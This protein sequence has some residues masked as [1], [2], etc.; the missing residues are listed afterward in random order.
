MR[1]MKAGEA[2]DPNHTF[3]DPGFGLLKSSSVRWGRRR[4]ATP[5]ARAASGTPAPPRAGAATS[6]GDVNA[7]RH[8]GKCHRRRLR[9]GSRA[10]WGHSRGLK[11]PLCTPSTPG[12]PASLR[13]GS[14]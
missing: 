14:S 11:A 5:L 13:P 2:T 3:L 6:S 9:S 4:L 7:R 12:A 1:R 10:V 8:I